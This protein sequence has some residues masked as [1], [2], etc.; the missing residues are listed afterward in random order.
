LKADAPAHNFLDPGDVLR[1]L[2]EAALDHRQLAISSNG[3]VNLT[4]L[5]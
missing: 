1:A 3:H 4:G 2:V 5:R